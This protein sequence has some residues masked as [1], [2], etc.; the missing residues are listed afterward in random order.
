MARKKSIGIRSNLKGL[1]SDQQFSGAARERGF[2]QRRRRVTR[3]VRLAA[4]PR[5]HSRPSAD[6]SV[7]LHRLRHGNAA[8]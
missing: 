4:A 5:L 7:L 1:V 8:S 2:A 3:Q 6:R